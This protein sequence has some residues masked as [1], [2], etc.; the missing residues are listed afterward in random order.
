MTDINKVLYDAHVGPVVRAPKLS[1]AAPVLH[2][3]SG[4]P[5]HRALP[6][7]SGLHAASP[8]DAL[9]AASS[10]FGA[11]YEYIGPGTIYDATIAV[12]VQFFSPLNV[13]GI[14]AQ[15]NASR[16][17][18]TPT[19]AALVAYFQDKFGGVTELTGYIIQFHNNTAAQNL[20]LTWTAGAGVSGLGFGRPYIMGQI[21]MIFTNVKPNQEAVSMIISGV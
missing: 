1:V 5:S 11:K 13:G 16:T 17:W 18:T 8:T 9:T 14:Y 6:I 10:D 4:Q 20:T 7:L 15:T 2:S 12:P 19:A 3:T 21:L